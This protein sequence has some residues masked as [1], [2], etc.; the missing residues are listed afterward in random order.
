MVCSENLLINI[1]LY[2]FYVL[3]DKRKPITGMGCLEFVMNKSQ[4]DIKM[5]LTLALIDKGVQDSDLI[6]KLVNSLYLNIIKKSQP[7]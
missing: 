2:E 3:I 6:N 7:S 4:E 5:D 1:L